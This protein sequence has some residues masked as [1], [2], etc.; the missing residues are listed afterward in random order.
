MY[1]ALSPEIL[2][3]PQPRL[4]HSLRCSIALGQSYFDSIKNSWQ[5]HSL[6]SRVF[7]LSI[8]FD[9]N[10]VSIQVHARSE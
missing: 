7:N 9:F 8:L 2:I 4:R 5:Q 3:L 10:L 6:Y 1:H